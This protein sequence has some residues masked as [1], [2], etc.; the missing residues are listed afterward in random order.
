MLIRFTAE[1]FLSFHQR[2]DFN[3]IANNN[4]TS[5][6]QHIVKAKNENEVDLLRSS[7]IYGANA[8]GKS[9]LI[10]AIAF[11]QKLIVKGIDSENIVLESREN[12]YFGLNHEAQNKITR[13]EFEIKYKA[14][15][16]AYG[17]E[18]NKFGIQEEWLFEIRKANEDKIFERK[19][20]LIQI[21]FDYEIFKN[22]NDDEKNE[23]KYE[24][25][26]SQKNLF[27]HS[28]NQKDKGIIYFK[29]IFDWFDDVLTVIFPETSIDLLLQ[30]KFDSNF[31]EVLCKKIKLFDFGIENV[32]SKTFPFKDVH[33]IPTKLKEEIIK[34]F[35]VGKN[36]I[37]FLPLEN[38]YLIEDKDNKLY[39]SKIITQRKDNL[40]NLID[41]DFAQESDGTRRIFDFIP[42]MTKFEEGE[43][44]FVIDEIERSLHSLLSKNLFDLLLNATNQSESQ[45]IATTHEVQLMDIKKLFRKDEIWLVEKNE[46]GESEFYSLAGANLEGLDL[47]KGYLK[48]RYGAIPFLKSPLELGF[49]S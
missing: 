10:K 22:L 36:M 48:G 11:A 13:F 3:M 1:N 45:I 49:E 2:I 46:K 16:Y 44:V 21:N 38:F 32:A 31:K 35:E 30:L 41:F 37:S 26:R 23:L 9:N 27:L 34:H 47:I 19:N 28:I 33:D 18:F 43:Q 39:A 20:N 4:D 29:E 5:F 42:I 15:Q 24:S 7:L 8:S 6:E 25:K 14:K 17:F 12:F 40:G